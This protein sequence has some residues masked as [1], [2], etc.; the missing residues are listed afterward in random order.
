MAPR[1]VWGCQLPDLH[2]EWLKITD[3][4]ADTAVKRGETAG[5]RRLPTKRAAYFR[6]RLER[7]VR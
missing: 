4:N 1:T 6:Q 5:V 3:A 7:T 2:G